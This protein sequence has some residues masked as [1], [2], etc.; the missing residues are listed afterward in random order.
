MGFL[1]DVRQAMSDSSVFVLPS[2]YLEGI[3][4]SALEALAMGKPVVTTDLP[5]C[6]ETAIQFQNGYLVPPGNVEC[7]GH[8]TIYYIARPCLADGN[9]QS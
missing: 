8:G 7:L 3:P 9:P 6:R 2:K 1:E 4:R 5:G